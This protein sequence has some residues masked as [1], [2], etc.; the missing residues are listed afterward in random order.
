MDTNTISLQ[1][2]FEILGYF[3]VTPLPSK[4]AVTQQL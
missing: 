3:I 4:L 1:E 2:T